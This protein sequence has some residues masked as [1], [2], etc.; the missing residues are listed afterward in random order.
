MSRLRQ[1]I[2]LLCL[3]GTTAHGQLPDGVLPPTKNRATAASKPSLWVGIKA[4]G[5][6]LHPRLHALVANQYE[7]YSTSEFYQGYR[8]GMFLRKDWKR[9][10]AGVE[11]TYFSNQLFVQFRNL[12]PKS[13]ANAEP[14]QYDWY[15]TGTIYLLKRAEL[16]ASGAYRLTRWLRVGAG[17]TGARQISEK[18]RDPINRFDEIIARFPES[19]R[20]FLLSGRAGIGADLGRFTADFY[21]ERS[22]TPM[23][24]HL[25]FNGVN[26][27]LRQ[28]YR[29]L[30]L[31]IGYKIF[32][33]N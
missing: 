20:P 32:R 16:T 5:N 22:L 28:H 29:L 2:F 7:I 19:Y 14:G 8:L 6:E 27:P 23:S 12:D 18:Y 9:L 4:E 15:Y 26:Y 11:L 33:L 30:G 10:Q 31:S 25:P 24:T 21:V 1:Q 3:L 13:N 17:L